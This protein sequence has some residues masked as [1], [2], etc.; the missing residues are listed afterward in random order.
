MRLHK[1]ILLYPLSRNA[2]KYKLVIDTTHGQR[3]G[4]LISK[5]SKNTL[6][7][8]Y[9]MGVM[10]M[11]SLMYIYLSSSLMM[12]Y[13]DR[14]ASMNLHKVRVHTYLLLQGK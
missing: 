1:I 4:R 10:N 6:H 12:N 8:E 13:E 3:M 7:V 11:R 9:G 14:E 2:T 5:R